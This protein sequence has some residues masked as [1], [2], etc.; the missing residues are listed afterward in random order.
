MLEDVGISELEERAYLLLLKRGRASSSELGDGVGVGKSEILPVLELL[1]AKGLVSRVPGTPTRFLPAPPQLAI[2]GLV[3]RQRDRL[4]LIRPLGAQLEREFRDTLLIDRAVD[5]VEV[6][7]SKQAVYER[8]RQLHRSA[9]TEILSLSKPPYVTTDDAVEIEAL[10]HDVRHRVIYDRAALE[11]LGDLEGI[12]Q[13]VQAGE[14]ARVLTEVPMKLLIVDHN[15]GMVPLSI[16]Q[17]DVGAALLVHSSSLLDALAIMFESLWERALPLAI[18]VSSE[19]AD[20]G[21]SEGA[22]DEL[23]KLL[24]A[25]QRRLVT[26]MVAGSKDAVIARQLGVAPRT[27]RR[28]VADLLDVLGAANRFQAGYQACRRGLL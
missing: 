21:P 15:T 19:D 24:S 22:D 26:L 14:E 10:A 12:E 25:E 20:G 28:R 13:N 5:L 11:I 23:R 16:Q 17:E 1:E 2:E 6:I 3:N 9:R 18:A 27:L 4:E 7:T 8:L